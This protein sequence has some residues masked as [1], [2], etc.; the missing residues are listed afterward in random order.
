[1]TVTIDFN[2]GFSVPVVPSSSKQKEG[3]NSLPSVKTK[4]ISP[5]KRW[6]FT[7]F[8]FPKDWESSNSSIFKYL[9]D[10]ERDFIIY[11]Y[12]ICPGTKR[13]HLQGYI[14]FHTKKRPLSTPFPTGVNWLKCKGDRLSNLTYC[15]KDGRFISNFP[16]HN[17]YIQE[18][19]TFYKWELKIIEMLKEK[20]DGRKIYAYWSNKGEQGK[21]TFSKWIYTHYARVV[22]LSGAASDMKNCI[23]D[24]K[25]MNGR[26]PEII[27]LNYPFCT[28][29]NRISYNGIEEIK[30]MFFYSG[31]Y[32]GGMI[33]HRPPHVLMFSNK[34]P[35][36]EKMSENRWV[37]E[38]IEQ[39]A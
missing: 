38:N 23:V 17:K 30:D 6:C 10:P 26:T 1:M 25:L 19:T 5:A 33:C 15:S 37:I 3:N 13:P 32:K 12:E 20:P 9:P 27:I 22:V 16:E 21:T 14:E 11:G 2:G 36:I 29:M 35:I 8:D 4:Q 28:N 18:I 24:Y 39:E 7:W 34:P 31:K